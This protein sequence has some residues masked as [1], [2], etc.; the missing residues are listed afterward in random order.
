MFGLVSLLLVIAIAAMWLT[1]GM[2]GTVTVQNDDGTVTTQ[3]GYVEA[4]DQA[5]DAARMMEQ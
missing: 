1:A 5:E 4:V 3:S 2:G